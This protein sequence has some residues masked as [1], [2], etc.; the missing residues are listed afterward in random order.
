MPQADTLSLRAVAMLR[1]PHYAHMTTL[2]PDGAPQP[3]VV[4]VDVED[5]GGHMIVNSSIRRLKLRNIER[6]PRVSV[7]VLDAANALRFV[8]VR[9]T[10][11]SVSAE[12]AEEH[13]Q[14]L[15]LKYDGRRTARTD[16]S[17]RRILWIKPDHVVE[18]A[19]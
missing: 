5:D 13:Y 18:R 2:M 11:V 9:G 7:S 8:I 1:K 12:G 4:W 15:S 14:Q 10:V 17:D 3:T 19:V 6:D 16:L